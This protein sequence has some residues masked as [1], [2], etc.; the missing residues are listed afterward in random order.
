MYSEVQKSRQALAASQRALKRGIA[1]G[2]PQ[3][4]L[5]TLQRIVDNNLR[6]YRDAIAEREANKA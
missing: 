4:R 5:R 3:E 2:V 1:D 6:R